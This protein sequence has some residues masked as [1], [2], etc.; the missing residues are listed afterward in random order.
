M[1]G[2]LT[3]LDRTPQEIN[4]VTKKVLLDVYFEFVYPH[5]ER[6]YATWEAGM[7]TMAQIGRTS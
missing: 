2:K 1:Q 7:Q 6:D 4:A 5:R 3:I